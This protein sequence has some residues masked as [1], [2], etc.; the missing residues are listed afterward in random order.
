[1]LVLLRDSYLGKLEAGDESIRKDE[2]LG[3]FFVSHKYSNKF[4]DCYLV[5]ILY[6]LCSSLIWYTV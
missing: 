4:R 5:Y 3:E 2:T 6:S 1:M